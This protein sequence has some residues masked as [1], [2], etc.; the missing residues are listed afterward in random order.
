MARIEDIPEPTRAHI[1]ALDCPSWPEQPFVA[2]PP[3]AK[4]RV[5][6]VT[7]AALHPRDQPPFPAGTAEVRMLPAGLPAASIVMSH[8]SINFDR[9]GF[10]R[11]LN[12]AYPIDRLRALAAEGAIGEVAPT[13]YA[14][15]GSTDPRTM[16]ETAGQIAGQMR[17]EQVDAAL[18]VP[19]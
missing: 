16:E 14:V 19:V 10:Q 6:I 12:T 11:D 7:S 17:Q 4:R 5:A 9:T 3:L 15:M 1:L 2:G 13:H 8:I 18:L